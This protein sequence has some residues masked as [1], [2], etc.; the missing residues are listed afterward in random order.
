[1]DDNGG[2]RPPSY[3]RLP[4]PSVVN[5]A[6]PGDA[7]PPLESHLCNVCKYLNLSIYDFARLDTKNG[8][9][10]RPDN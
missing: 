5:H 3:F 1:M 9:M 4:A 6:L 10:S 7:L 2:Y 8:D